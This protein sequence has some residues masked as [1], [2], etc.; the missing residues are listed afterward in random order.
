MLTGQTYK[1]FVRALEPVRSTLLP[2]A[3][4][5]VNHGFKCWSSG[6]MQTDATAQPEETVRCSIVNVSQS[7]YRAD[8]GYRPGQAV[9][10]DDRVLDSCVVTLA[11]ADKG[12]MI[13]PA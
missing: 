2:H 13:W 5:D 7:I 4:S 10:H 9:H 1:D 12:T 8:E 3:T 11:L 6:W